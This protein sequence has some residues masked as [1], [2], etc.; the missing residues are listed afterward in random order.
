VL[1]GVEGDDG[2]VQRK[3]AHG[4]DPVLLPLHELL[5]LHNDDSSIGGLPCLLLLLCPSLAS[6]AVDWGGES[7]VG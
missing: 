7:L 6:S 5:R 2:V 1:A 3:V 4:D